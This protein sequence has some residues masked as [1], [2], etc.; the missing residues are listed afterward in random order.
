[1]SSASLH[2]GR[3]ANGVCRASG[4]GEVAGRKAASGS[5][6]RMSGVPEFSLRCS[7]PSAAPCANVPMSFVPARTTPECLSIVFN[8]VQKSVCV[9]SRR[10]PASGT[11]RRCSSRL[12]RRPW[13]RFRIP[14]EVIH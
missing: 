8:V 3:P 4:V 1:M 13:R 6:C 14:Y 7:K 12:V 5:S 11:T 10:G 9:S 2:T